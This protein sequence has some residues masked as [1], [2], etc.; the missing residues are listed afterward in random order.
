MIH[1]YAQFEL[2]LA[3][4]QRNVK[5]KIMVTKRC[6]AS[7]T[8]KYEVEEN[9]LCG[10][11]TI[12]KEAILMIGKSTEPNIARNQWKHCENGSL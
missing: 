12:S 2:F 4:C 7:L 6:V 5:Q 1:K 11:P 10:L 3:R 9:S 8:S